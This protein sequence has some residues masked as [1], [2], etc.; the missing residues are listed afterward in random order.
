MGVSFISKHTIDLGLHTGRFVL[1]Q[2]RYLLR[3]QVA[4]QG[5]ELIRLT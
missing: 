3:A 1:T 5:T 4:P 2:G